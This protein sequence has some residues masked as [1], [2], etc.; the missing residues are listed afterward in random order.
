[1]RLDKYTPPLLWGFVM[2]LD[3]SH[4]AFNG[5][6][7]GFNR[8]RQ[9]VSFLAGGS[10]PPH[11][12]RDKQGSV[13]NKKDDFGLLLRDEKLDEHSWY[14]DESYPVE[15][16]GLRDFLNHSDCDGILTAQQ[17]KNVADELEDLLKDADKFEG[18]KNE[19][20]SIKQFVAGCR[21]AHMHGENLEFH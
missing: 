4:N 3:C 1:M 2:G 15:K 7:G 11:Y 9:A 6:Y 16:T 19:L 20:N 14:V 21:K 12:K 17:C 10:Y 18:F 13:L 5:S 8:L